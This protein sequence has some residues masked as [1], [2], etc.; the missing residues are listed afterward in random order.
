VTVLDRVLQRPMTWRVVCGL[1]VLIHVAYVLAPF[2]VLHP[3]DAHELG[4][5]LLRGDIPYRDFALEYPPGALVGFILPGLVPSGIAKSVLAL[6][7]LVCEIVVWRI[8]GEDAARRRFVLFTV[9]LFPLLSGGFDALTMLTVA[10]STVLLVRGDHRG[11]WVAAFGAT[12]KLFPGTAWGWNPRWGRTGV[13][14]L[15]VTVGVL[16]APLV[17]G[18]G[19]DVYVAYHVERG[20]QQESLAASA[21]HLGARLTGDE[22]DIEYRFRAQEVVGA[23]G[24]GVASL[25]AF[26]ALAVAMALRVRF[27]PVLL[28]PWVVALA[29]M[30]VVLCGSKVLSPQFVVIAMPLAVGAG[31]L[32]AVSYVP[33]AALSIAAFLD[34]SKGEQFMDVVLVRNLLFLGLALV[35]AHRVLTAPQRVN[36]H[37]TPAMAE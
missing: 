14:A 4:R 9:L 24:I 20:V 33:V 22:V 26:G 32:W 16:L 12:I 23:E 31:G 15:V 30:L 27:R 17:V 8:L 13:I 1:A 6:Q 37:V 25:L 34:D 35:A 11:W 5:A 19:R 3:V 29:F 36:P 28:D 2:D 21:S 18:Q 7:A 10:A